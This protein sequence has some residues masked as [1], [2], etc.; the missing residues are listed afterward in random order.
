MKLN[1]NEC[2]LEKVFS[3]FNTFNRSF[4]SLRVAADSFPPWLEVR[5]DNDEVQ[6]FGILS[7]LLNTLSLSMKIKFLVVPTNETF[8]EETINNSFSSEIVQTV[9]RKEAE[10]GLISLTPTQSAFRIVDF[11]LPYHIENLVVL[12]GIPDALPT[13]VNIFQPQV[14]LG[15]VIS[16][17]VLLIVG[18][19]IDRSQQGSESILNRALRRLNIISEF[20]NEGTQPYSATRFLILVWLVASSVIAMQCINVTNRDKGDRNNI[21]NL[22]D[23]VNY[24]DMKVLAPK[25]LNILKW[26]IESRN[27]KH[28]LLGRRMRDK[29]SFLTM[30]QIFSESSL[31][32]VERRESAIIAGSSTVKMVLSKRYQSK[33]SCRLYLGKTTSFPIMRSIV[34]RK[35]APNAFKETINL[36]MNDIAQSHLFTHSLEAASSNYTICLTTFNQI[37]LLNKEELKS[38]FFVW[39]AGVGIIFVFMAIEMILFKNKLRSH[40]NLGVSVHLNL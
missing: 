30:N 19:L 23:L 9:H 26:L 34:L 10:L 17:M 1:E 32:D 5:R 15:L 11:I 7:D 18:I 40:T 27:R 2:V 33:K 21:E 31:D 28:R 14:W 24:P 29:N 3:C 39:V 37:R 12:S 25:G 6:L 4:C 8:R 35:D 38:L 13:Y 20:S 16:F 36:R 22:E